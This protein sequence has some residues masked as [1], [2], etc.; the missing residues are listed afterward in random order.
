MTSSLYNTD[1]VKIIT[2]S[3]L[4]L[5]RNA[6]VSYLD[7][8]IIFFTANKVCISWRDIKFRKNVRTKATAAICRNACFDVS[9]GFYG[10]AFTLREYTDNGKLS[11]YE[12]Y[13]FVK[14]STSAGNRNQGMEI[15][16]NLSILTTLFLVMTR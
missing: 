7:H 9:E 8:V 11:G 12:S 5:S 3:N 14:K 13:K 6:K 1:R 10:P 15:S 4:P 16:I 2:L